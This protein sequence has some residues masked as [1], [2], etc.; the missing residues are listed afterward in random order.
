MRRIGRADRQT[1]LAALASAWLLVAGCASY[2]PDEPFEPEEAEIVVAPPPAAEA[3]PAPVR[4]PPPPPPLPPVAIVLTS[5]QPA[6]ADVAAALAGQLEDY[7]VYDLSA[8]GQP[9]VTVLRAVNDSAASA[10]IAIGLRAAQSSVA[11]A[12][13]PVIFSQVFNYQD[14]DLLTASS[15]GVEALPP[16]AAQLAA[17]RQADPSLERIGTIVG[18]GHDS[19]VAAA[20]LAAREL[21]LELLA[22]VARSDQE[23]L[24]LFRRMIRD[25][26]GFW[27]LPDN[28]ILSQRVL[29][30]MLADAQRLHVP[31]AVPNDAMLEMGAAVSMMAEPGDIAATI[32]DLLRKIQSGRLDSIPPM[33]PLS[34]IRVTS[35]DAPQVA[36]R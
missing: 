27:L 36:E 23:T 32:V 28:R 21:G 29:G 35:R 26:D 20:E 15:R 7:A 30:Q 4:V 11:I 25:I 13:A 24:Y 8:G 9:P 33:S 5:S 1:L 22:Q 31:V 3:A 10:V 17:W 18:P 16:P 2:L 6:Y 14:E 12:T 34:A 19:L